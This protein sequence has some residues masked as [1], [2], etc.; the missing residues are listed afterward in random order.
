MDMITDQLS[1]LNLGTELPVAV[2]KDSAGFLLEEIGRSD[3]D[4][5][6]LSHPNHELS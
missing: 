2:G 5:E 4:L 3:P 1:P 6:T